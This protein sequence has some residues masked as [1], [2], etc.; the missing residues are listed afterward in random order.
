MPK[1]RKRHTPFTKEDIRTVITLW[2]EKSNQ[3][4][5]Q[6]LGRN[7]ASICYIANAIRKEGFDLPKKTK[8]GTFNLLVKEV[9]LEMGGFSKRRG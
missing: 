3:E 7:T 8:R 5:A 4:I 9:L 2:E 1:E 6:E